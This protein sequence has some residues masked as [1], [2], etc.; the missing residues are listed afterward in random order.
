MGTPFHVKIITPD[1][2]FFDGITEQIIAK[3]TEGDVGILANHI[4]YVATLP[5]SPLKIKLQDG[6]FKIAAISGGIIKVSK[7]NTTII[8]TA[9]EWSDE[10]DV[11]WAKRSEEDAREKLKIHNSGVEFE[12]ANLKLKRALNRISVSKNN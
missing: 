12:R 9:A 3:T 6:T 10:I 1:K 4:N 8:T 11:K 2:E 7:K 5:A